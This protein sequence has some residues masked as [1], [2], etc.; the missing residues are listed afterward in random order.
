MKKVNKWVIEHPEEFREIQRRTSKKRRLKLKLELFTL[1]GGKCINPFGSHDKP[2]TDIRCLQ[3]D[4][5][6]GGGIKDYKK[7]TGS[8]NGGGEM[9]YK[10]VL[11]EIK[12]GSK[13]YQ[14]LCA[15]CNWIKRYEKKEI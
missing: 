7:K 6:N 4:H 1:L 5:V 8:K 14:L 11:V 13:D 2:F 3:V 10:K 9:Y 12:A 15:N